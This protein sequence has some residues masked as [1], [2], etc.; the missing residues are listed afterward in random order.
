MTIEQYIESINKRYRLDNPTEHT[1]RSDLQQ[2]YHR[3]K[4][5]LENSKIDDGVEIG[6]RNFDS[7][8]GISIVCCIF[9]SVLFCW[10]AI[11][12]K[13]CCARFNNFVVV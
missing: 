5:I 2:L 10:I 11:D 12:A 6:V 13:K 7:F 4:F 9:N 8:S 1:F 3:E